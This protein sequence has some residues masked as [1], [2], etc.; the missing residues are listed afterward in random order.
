MEWFEHLLTHTADVLR[1]I[2]EYLSVLCVGVG[3]GVGLIA[4]F[5]SR[6]PLRSLLRRHLPPHL[7]Q[8][9]PLTAARLPFGGW[10]A[11]V[12]EFQLGADVVQTTISREVSDL[13]A[14]GAVA[15]VRTSLNYFLSLELQEK[16]K[17][18]RVNQGCICSTAVSGSC[19]SC[20]SPGIFCQIPFTRPGK[21]A[22]RLE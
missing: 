11:L 13:I 10:L 7:L 21:H 18:P 17:R 1:L 5:S 20:Q 16:R 3:V 14:L 6:G 8:R 22:L 4:V 19:L 12:L 2:L 15:V 9:G